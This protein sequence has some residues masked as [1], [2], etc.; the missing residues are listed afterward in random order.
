[1]ANQTRLREVGIDLAV[2]F[3]GSICI[4]VGIYNFAVH[5]EF[6]MTGFSGVAMIVNRLTGFPIG[7]MTILLNL[8]VAAVCCRLLGRGFFIKSIRCMV[9]S[10]VMI[11]YAAP[12]FP[13]FQGDRMLA[14]ICTGVIAG[15]GYAIIFMRGSSTGGTDFIVMA[16]KVLRP[17]MSLGKIVFLADAGV[18]LAGGILFRDVEGM[19]YGMIINYLFAVVV[20]KV[21]YGIDSGKLA[22]IVTEHGQQVVQEI[23]CCCGRGATIR[24][25]SGGYPRQDKQVVMC[26]CSNKQM[27]TVQ[28]QVKAADA[29]SFIIILESNEVLG[30]G[31]KGA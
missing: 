14:A 8:P 11:D 19:V 13:A 6:P 20:D 5:A 16:V 17:H 9:I 15:F 10:S 2:E 3:F 28:K 7:I 24:K 23:E 12:L 26:A 31:F 22:L 18:V 21:A 25:A 30:E 29:D 27:Y 1:M 4:A